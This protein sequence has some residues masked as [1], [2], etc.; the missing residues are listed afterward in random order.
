MPVPSGVPQGSVLGPTLFLIYV[1]D[2][3][4][5][6]NFLLVQYADDTS[7]LAPLVSPSTCHGL[8][9]YLDE[10][11]CW[12]STNYLRLSPAK[13][14]TMRFSSART[15]QKPSYTLHG[16]AVTV[17]D[18]V[19]ILGVQYVRTLDFHAHVA[20]VVAKS[21][22]TLGFVTRVTK[23]C[24]PHAFRLLYT[25]LVLPL[26]EYCS[27]VWSPPQQHLVA[28]IESV[29]RRASHT[30][31]SRSTGPAARLHYEERLVVAKWR[32]LAYRRDIGRVRLLCRVFDGSLSGTF[33]SSQVRVSNRT[34]QPQPMRAR[35]ARH[36]TSLVPAAVRGFLSL[37]A[38]QRKPLPRGREESLELCRSYA[39]LLLTSAP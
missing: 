9:A 32:Q 29:Q 25:S 30:L 35:T 39:R 18:C 14:C 23:Q 20:S 34:G 3:P 38:S 28:R 7:I 22:R 21:R 2:M 24:D 5:N 11:A 1:N 17:T 33:L 8:Q 15:V 13:S 31:V 37:P 10:I 19:T 12:A 4:R 16:E 36:S 6:E 27:A 26:L